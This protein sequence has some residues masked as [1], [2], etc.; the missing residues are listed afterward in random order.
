MHQRTHISKESS[1]APM[2][3]RGV[4]LII[5]ML[6]LVFM[7]LLA[8][9]MYCSFGIDQKIA[10]NSMEKARAFEAAQS[11]LQLGENWIASG[12]ASAPANCSAATIVSTTVGPPICT[13]PMSNPAT[14]PWAAPATYTIPGMTVA[15]GGG[16]NSTSGDINYSSAPGI[17]IYYLG[18]NAAQTTTY[19]Q[20]DAVGYGG[21]TSTTSIVESIYAMTSTSTSSSKVTDLGGQ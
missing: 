1:R 2:A 10:G 20:V 7:T 17:Y 16:T 14:L 4:V 15:T 13:N 3:Q 9:S 19:Y 6:M 5:S 21:S 11:A 18:K 12:N 8:V